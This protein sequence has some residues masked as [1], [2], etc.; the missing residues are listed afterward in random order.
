MDYFAANDRA[1]HALREAIRKETT[2]AYNRLHSIDE[3][4][5]FV[6]NI[7]SAYSRLPLIRL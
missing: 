6:A 3:D 4:T 7:H 1:T 2:D 5:A